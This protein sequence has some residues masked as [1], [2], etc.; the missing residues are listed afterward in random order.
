MSEKTHPLRIIAG[1]CAAETEAQVLSAA[2][3]LRAL[4]V[5][6]FRACLW[7]PRT[8]PGFDGVKEEGIPWL[9]TAS[10]LGLTVST[11]VMQ[12]RQVAQLADAVHDQN[13]DQEIIVWNG[14]RHQNHFDL[15]EIAQEVKGREKV[16]LA[17][18]NQPWPDKRHW[19]GMVDHVLSTGLSEERILLCHR[20]FFPGPHDPNPEGFR[21]WMDLEMMLT[22]QEQTQLP[23]I[24]DPSHIG[25]KR[26]K[27]KNLITW[28]LESGL[29]IQG[30][31]VEVH[32]N[33]DVAWTDAVQQLTIQEFGL[34]VKKLGLVSVQETSATVEKTS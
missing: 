19:L 5:T 33:P 16:T 13:A 22:V 31:M 6:E 34:L 24:L 4:G 17:L 15:L 11:E 12:A 29:P 8:E 18:K 9:V 1:P 23:M 7:K 25:G 21:N 3:Q 14:S 27:V 20:G 26:E 32:P 2:T 10:L 30:L 28:V